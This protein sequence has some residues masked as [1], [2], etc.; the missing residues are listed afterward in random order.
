MPLD[1]TRSSL[2]SVRLRNHAR[3]RS[4]ERD[5]A[6]REAARNDTREGIRRNNEIGADATETLDRRT[7]ENRVRRADDDARGTR[8][9]EECGRGG[10]R[11]RGV[12][13]IIHEDC[14]PSAH[15]RSIPRAKP[16]NPRD[17][18]SRARLFEHHHLGTCEERREA[19][20]AIPSARIRRDDDL[21][22]VQH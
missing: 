15:A 8:R 1:H 7:G 3:Q 4:R 20:R 18:R 21:L 22:T 19:T 9:A 6:Q 12:Y 17:V 5:D 14:Y 16:R 2:L 10:D 13:D 11:P